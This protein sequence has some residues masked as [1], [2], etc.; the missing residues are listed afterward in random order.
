MR[1]LDGITDS[2]DICLSKIREIVKDKEAWRLQL[3]GPQRLRHD[4]AAEQR[5]QEIQPLELHHVFM[6]PGVALAD[7]AL[8]AKVCGTEL[9][10]ESQREWS[11]KEGR[12]GV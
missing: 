12:K 6:R 4:L 10:W 8:S 1:R 11:K 5:Q 3:M 9:C 7:G 2:M